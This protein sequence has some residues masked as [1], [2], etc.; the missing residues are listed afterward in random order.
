[1]HRRSQIVL[2]TP[3]SLR[4]GCAVGTDTLRRAISHAQAVGNLLDGA[5][6]G[7]QIETPLLLNEAYGAKP[8]AGDDPL[9]DLVGWR[10][11]VAELHAEAA[12]ITGLGV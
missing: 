9:L 1:M 11:V 3:A 10:A 4:A 2:R 7:R 5:L 6:G 12:A 8:I